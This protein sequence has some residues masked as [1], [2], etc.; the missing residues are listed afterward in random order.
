M[1][2]ATVSQRREL[3]SERF[4]KE[5]EDQRAEREVRRHGLV[6]NSVADDVTGQRHSASVYSTS[7]DRN[8]LALLLHAVR[9]TTL[10]STTNIA[11]RMPTIIRSDS[12]RCS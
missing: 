7:V 3:A 12:R 4:L 10:V 8:P 6:A 11:I 1:I 5:S 2:E 9:K